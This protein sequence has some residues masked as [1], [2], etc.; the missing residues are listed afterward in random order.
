MWITGNQPVYLEVPVFAKTVNITNK[1]AG[2]YL[3]KNISCDQWNIRP[4]SKIELINNITTTGNLSAENFVINLSNK[5]LN[6]AGEAKFTGTLQINNEYNANTNEGGNIQITSGKFDLSGAELLINTSITS[7][8]NN[9]PQKIEYSLVSAIND[10]VIIAPTQDYKLTIEDNNRFINWIGSMV[11]N[12]KNLTLTAASTILKAPA[13]E[14]PPSPLLPPGP[15]EPSTLLGANHGNSAGSFVD[16][17][18]KARSDTG[19]S[20]DSFVV[21]GDVRPDSHDSAGSFVDVGS[22][23]RGF[24]EGA[25][26]WG[27]ARGQVRRL[28][29]INDDTNHLNAGNMHDELSSTGDN[30]SISADAPSSEEG[31]G[32]TN[33]GISRTI[34]ASYFG[35]I[36]AN[37]THKSTLI[38]QN[39]ANELISQELNQNEEQQKFAV[40]LTQVTNRVSD[41]ARFKNSLGLFNKETAT[42]DSREAADRLITRN[43]PPSTAMWESLKGMH[44]PADQR[45]LELQTIANHAVVSAGNDDETKKTPGFWIAPFAA[46]A[47]QKQHHGSN[48]YKLNMQG[49]TL[50]GD[51]SINDNLVFGVAYSHLTTNLKYQGIKIGDKAKVQTNIVSLYGVQFWRTNCFLEGVLSY[52]WSKV[53][54]NENRKTLSNM[55]HAIGKYTARAYSGQ[56]VAGYNYFDDKKVIITPIIG[57]SYIKF[58]DAIYHESDTSYQNLKIKVKSDYKF[59]G[60]VGIRVSTLIPT[61]QMLIIPELHGNI[62]YNIKGKSPNIEARMDGIDESLPTKAFKQPKIFYNVGAGIMFK[63]HNQPIEYGIKYNTTLAKRYISHQGSMKIKVNF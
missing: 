46:R 33:A 3:G 61:D 42:A 40:Q 5:K 7:D 58:R 18:G 51:Y 52:G 28:A 49:G 62:H 30:A 35:D 47:T 57:L 11:S 6:Y 23:A 31:A 44:Q 20:A 12:N 55:E 59:E 21:V 34:G 43:I 60:L 15:A 32:G 27:N 22:N 45:M 48:G 17:G 19:G 50:G 38:P 13:P 25:I 24:A 53:K 2:V 37:S 63:C 26:S 41:A 14:T 39:S 54:I 4:G 10:A 1:A 36:A 9:L 29:R 8:I 16:V 56:L